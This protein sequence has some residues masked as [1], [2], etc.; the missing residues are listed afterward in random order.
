MRFQFTIPVLAAAVLAAGCAGHKHSEA[1]HEHEAELQLTAYSEHYEVYAEAEPFAAGE[2]STVRAHVTSLDNFKPY[3]GGGITA[4]VTYGGKTSDYAADSH[5]VAGIYEFTFTPDSAGEGTISF[6]IAGEKVQLPGIEVFEDACQAH[7]AAEKAHASSSNGVAFSKEISWKSDFSTAL[8]DRSPFGTVIRTVA[9]VLP[10]AS[11]EYTV[12]A[13][14]SGIVQIP[15]AGLVEGQEVKAGQTLFFLES[16]DMADNNLAVRYKEAES[17]Y[18]LARMEYERKRG[19][20]ADRIVSEAELLRAESEFE[21]AKAVYENMLRNFA[22]GRPAGKAPFSGYLKSVSVSNGDYVE[23]GSPVLT[24]T[25]NREIYLKA[26][27]RPK[28]YG[29]MDK[30]ASVNFRTLNGDRLYSLEE[31]GGRMVSYGRA[32]G[33]DSP[34][35][36]VTFRLDNAA[37]LLPGTFVELFINTRGTED[38]LTVPS[39]AIVEEMGNHFVYVQLTPE[40]FEKTE[41]KTGMTDGRRTEILSGLDGSERVV[42]RGAILVKLAQSAGT[43]DSHSGHVH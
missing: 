10:S 22:E 39:E 31:Y 19:L 42:A 23:A 4:G 27:I 5:D 2:E 1:E 43:L 41:V 26:E 33:T 25:R 7:E 37:G 28:Y 38:V 11:D 18:N 34:L 14:A 30:V 40:F 29:L 17:A 32:L 16:G 13:K 9:Q 8:C 3:V 6:G 35:L 36:P 12:T 21:T 24:L 20:A 15:A